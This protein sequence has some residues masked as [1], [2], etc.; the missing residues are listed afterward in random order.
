MTVHLTAVLGIDQA[1]CSGWALHA[2]GR[3][4]A[5]G[6]ASTAQE[7]ANVVVHALQL[8]APR[9]LL[10]VLE[11]H[12]KM[13]LMR[14]TQFDSWAKQAPTR[15]AATLVGMGDAR[16]RWREQLELA[17]VPMSHVLYVEPKVWRR[18]VLGRGAASLGTQAAK[19]LAVSW[20]SKACG[21]TVTDDNEAEA[22]AIASWGAVAGRSAF[23]A[24]QHAAR[25][26]AGRKTAPR[27]EA[28]ELGLIDV[29]TPCVSGDTCQ[30]RNG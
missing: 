24:T 26:R 2:D 14:N 17:G 20:A 9:S 15:N 5:S 27:G 22:V 23:R 19:Q 7:R 3:I 16:G 21:R 10:V 25:A 8:A 4:V 12:G 30:S 28:L 1:V 6:L 13:P 18:A 11:D 29:Q